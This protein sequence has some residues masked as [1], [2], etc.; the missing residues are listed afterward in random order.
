MIFQPE[1]PPAHRLTQV[2]AVFNAAEIVV[3]EVSLLRLQEGTGHSQRTVCL[4]VKIAGALLQSL[5]QNAAGNAQHHQRVGIYIA[6]YHVPHGNGAVKP[7]QAVGQGGAGNIRAAGLQLHLIEEGRDGRG[8]QR[9]G[10]LVLGPEGTAQMADGPVQPAVHILPEPLLGRGQLRVSG[11][12]HQLRMERSVFLQL[13]LYVSGGIAGRLHHMGSGVLL[14]SHGDMLMARQQQVEGKLLAQ[15]AALVFIRGAEAFAGAQILFQPAV[16]QADK[17]VHL[18]AQLFCQRPGR[19]YR[20]GQGEAGQIFRLFPKGHP[21]GHQ[22]DNAHS[23]AVFHRADCIGE[24]RQPAC[25]V[26]HVGAETLGVQPG[27]VAFQRAVAVVEVVV[28]QRD[29]VVLPVVQRVR[30]RQGQMMAVA[31]IGQGRTLNGVAAVDDQRVSI[32]GKAHG[33]QPHGSGLL[34]AEM[35]G[36]KIPMGIGGK[37]DRQPVRH[38]YPRARR[39]RIL[40]ESHSISSISTTM[41]HRYAPTMLQRLELMHWIRAAPMPPAPTM[42]SVVASLTL[43]SKR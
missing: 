31:V 32:L 21:V 5:P 19:L 4:Y 13:Y 28:A 24:E 2:E 9:H 37:V 3:V 33:K 15:T 40:V 16:V 17:H 1:D 20:V 29:K 25:P 43:M 34:V 41:P 22:P 38:A 12:S 36:V 8:F 7:A 11:G 27:Q 6:G 39:L 30:Y 42:P 14:V 18:T 26:G 23:K 35:T 10:Q